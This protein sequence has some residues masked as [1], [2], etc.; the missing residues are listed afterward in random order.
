MAG[1]GLNLLINSALPVAGECRCRN[2]GSDLCA[3][4]FGTAAAGNCRAYDRGSVP[5]SHV[6]DC[7]DP[8]TA[9]A[10]RGSP[11]VGI[12][13]SAVDRGAGAQTSDRRAARICCDH[14][15]RRTDSAG[16]VC[17]TCRVGRTDP[18]GAAGHAS[19]IGVVG[20]TAEGT[21]AAVAGRGSSRTAAPGP[22]G[23]IFATI[24][25]SSAG[26]AAR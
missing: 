13:R 9:L 12:D 15:G 23:C 2:Y 25:H 10:V 21:S 20:T 4:P 7:A 5:S 11:G 26:L 24:D 16:R 14:D 22:A 1:C 6:P 17:R 18:A 19:G 8:C 3:G